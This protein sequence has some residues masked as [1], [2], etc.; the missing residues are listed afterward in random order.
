MTTKKRRCKG[1][2]QLTDKLRDMS[3][4]E[5]QLNMSIKSSFTVLTSI[6]VTDNDGICSKC[7]QSLVRCGKFI[8]QCEQSEFKRLNI[9]KSNDGETGD[10]K[11]I[12][13]RIEGEQ[14][15]NKVDDKAV[16]FDDPIE[17]VYES[18]FEEVASE[19]SDETS[20][21][22]DV[23][24]QDDL[25]DVHIGPNPIVQHFCTVCRELFQPCMQRR[26][27]VTYLH[28]CYFCFRSQFSKSRRP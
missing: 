25:K 16:Q 4:F 17:E 6:E 20:K 28:N 13:E 8:E 1:C 14:S 26:G 24:S 27:F 9:I 2:Y 5:R 12:E 10:E 15:T 18:D 7:L 11:E 19:P 21:N 22:K 23:N 3:R